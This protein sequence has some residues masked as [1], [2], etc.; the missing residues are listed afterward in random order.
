MDGPWWAICLAD[1]RDAVSVAGFCVIVGAAFRY[2]DPHELVEMR[3]KAEAERIAPHKDFGPIRD[4]AFETVRAAIADG[5][6][7]LVDARGFL[8]SS[9]GRIEGTIEIP[10]GQLVSRWHV[11]RGQLQQRKKWTVILF[12]QDAQDT[13]PDA[14]AAEIAARGVGPIVIYRGGWKDWVDKGAPTTRQ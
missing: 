3:V 14:V 11:L 9:R 1:F 5:T 7:V 13:A 8:H 2:A 12:G 6:G 4:V 10:R